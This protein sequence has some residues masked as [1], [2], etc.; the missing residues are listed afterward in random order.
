MVPSGAIVKVFSLNEYVV[1]GMDWH[2]AAI[3]YQISS[4]KCEVTNYLLYLTLIFK[5]LYYT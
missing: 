3:S 2:G 4:Q 1:R 5:Y